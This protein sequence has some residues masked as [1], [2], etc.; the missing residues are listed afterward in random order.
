MN[1]VFFSIIMPVYNA[2]DFLKESLESVICQTYKSYELILV[3]DG[4]SDNSYNICNEYSQKYNNI[5]TTHQENQGVSIARNTGINIARGN[6]I[7]FID[8]DDFMYDCFALE[9]LSKEIHLHDADCYQFKTFRKN[10]NHLSVV[11]A[12]DSNQTFSLNDYGRMKLSRGEVWN[13]VF[14]KSII[15]KKYLRFKAGLKI[16]EDQ[17]FV[18]SYLSACTSVRTLNIPVYTYNLDNDNSC[19]H[20]YNYKKDLYDHILATSII[21]KANDSNNSFINERIAMMIL[22]TIFI[23]TKLP[24]S[25]IK[26]YE[27]FFKK[28]IKF[29]YKYLFNNKFIFV[30]SAFL[31]LNLSRTI[32][33]LILK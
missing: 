25:S 3:N 12:I 27:T 8:S 21:I 4:S 16:S 17:A 11:K 32:Y 18:Y 13:Y 10:K 15:D 31:S 7:L 26:E 9:L 28:H 5:I 14:K 33:R 6:F 1:K 22:H 2:Q 20:N 23:T 30:L 19:T 29:N 24:K